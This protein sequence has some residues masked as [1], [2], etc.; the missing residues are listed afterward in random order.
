M[1]DSVLPPKPTGPSYQDAPPPSPP[2]ST[3]NTNGYAIASLVL[4]IVPLL[5]VLFGFTLAIPG[6]S[7]LLSA[8]FGVLALRQIARTGDK[9]RGLAIG[10]L[11]LC[12]AWSVVLVVTVGNSATSGEEEA[13][14]DELSGGDTVFSAEQG[15]C[16]TGYDHAT[17]GIGEVS[18]DAPHSDEVYAV[19]PLP[20]SDTFPGDEALRTLSHQYCTTALSGFFVKSTM[21]ADLV[22]DVYYPPASA[23]QNQKHSVACTRQSISGPLVAPVAH[24]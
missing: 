12:G 6:I 18:C 13:A 20:E 1:S 17:G 19:V 23:W 5:K 10:G 2:P 8:I 9:G 21:P 4:A 16:F 7:L 11:G 22:V 15:A 3:G 24:H 14:V